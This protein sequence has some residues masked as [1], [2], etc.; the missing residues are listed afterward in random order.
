MGGPA[1]WGSIRGGGWMQTVAG[2]MGTEAY[3]AGAIRALLTLEMDESLLP[4]NATVDTLVSAVSAFRAY[5][6]G[7]K[8]AGIQQLVPAGSDAVV[9][10]RTPVEV[11]SIVFGGP[12]RSKGVFFPRGV[13]GAIKSS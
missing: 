6:G 2:I 4:F 12:N 9:Y 7:G 5:L 11:L 10:S 3:H 1:R 8:D 13:K